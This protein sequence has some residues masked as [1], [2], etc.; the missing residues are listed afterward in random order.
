MK[1]MI[2]AA[3]RGERMRPLTDHTPKPLLNIAGKSI[4]VYHIEALVAAGVEQIVINHAYLG[5]QIEAALGDGSQW[6]ARLRYSAET[7]ALETAGGILQALPLLGTEPFIVCNGDIWT[8]YDFAQLRQRDLSVSQRV[9]AHL[10]MVQNP[11]HHPEGDFVLADDGLLLRRCAVS[12]DRL[13][14][15]WSG[16]S[17]MDPQLLSAYEPGAR[18]LLQPLLAA[19]DQGLVSAE[20][21]GGDWIDIGSPQRL[22]QARQLAA[23][24]L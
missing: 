5:A 19:I 17:I 13:A 6:G 15:T 1:A 10:V 22:Q 9:L 14:V 2:L 7:S 11:Q 3:G 12:A 4:I 21:F 18:P 23:G 20:Y 16:I 24:A 8:D